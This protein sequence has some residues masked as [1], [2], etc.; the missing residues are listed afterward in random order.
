MG[1]ELKRV[2]MDFDWPMNTPWNGY[3]NPH[4]R[5]C[6]DCDG[7]GSTLADHRL[8]DLISFIMLS[9]D[10]ARKGTCHPYLQVAPLY[11]TQ[12]KVCGIEMAELTVAL[13]GREPSMLGHDAIDK[14]T[15]KRKILQ[16]AG[17]P[18]DWGSCSTCGGEGIHPDAKE[19][20]EAWE[21]FEPPTG[22]GYQIWETVSEGSP[23][24]PVF[25]TP[26][27]L[28]THMADT[29]WGADKGTDYETWLRFI[30]GPGWA[31]SMVGDAKG[32]RSGVEA[33]SET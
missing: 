31:P 10:D 6:Q 5:E 7:T 12:G 20:Y 8:S 4:Y 18:E 11:H 1:R 24:S 23:I 13:A 16:A 19:Q 9:G 29:R 27:E 30:N 3:L 26:E 22:E 25:A 17:L 33:M 15:A 2:P 28:A 32:L 14:W 21:R